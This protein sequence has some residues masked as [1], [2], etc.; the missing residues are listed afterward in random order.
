MGWTRYLPIL[1][2]ALG[3]G[4]GGCAGAEPELPTVIGE[5]TATSTEVDLEAIGKAYHDC[6]QDAGIETT[7]QANWRGELA[8]VV[9]DFDRWYLVYPPGGFTPVGGLK[10]D[11]PP[12][13]QALFEAAQAE[14]TEPGL[15]IDGIDH[16]QVYL[17][18]LNQTGYNED[19]AWAMDEVPVDTQAEQEQMEVNNRW[20]ACARDNGFPHIADSALPDDDMGPV[21]EIPYT[22]EP[23]QL[24]QLLVACPN[25]DPAEQQRFDEALA[26]GQ[27][28]DDQVPNPLITLDR[29]DTTG[30]SQA[31]I[32]RMMTLYEVLGEQQQAYQA[33]H[34][35]D[36]QNDPGQ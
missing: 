13:D 21:I 30:L 35:T 19:R 17:A 9:I 20:A 6:L 25:F 2:A 11:A 8:V 5:P 31:D 1:V 14:L 33:A 34:E 29:M 28:L 23:D 7:L 36:G 18:C 27:I 22:M 24:R 3:L 15:I 4:L 32:D 26:H 16:S 12:A 10:Q